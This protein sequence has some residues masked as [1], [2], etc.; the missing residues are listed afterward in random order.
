MEYMSK[1]FEEF[2]NEAKNY[3]YAEEQEIASMR[4][5]RTGYLLKKKCGLELD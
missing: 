3:T 1:Q 5:A 4:E 2:E